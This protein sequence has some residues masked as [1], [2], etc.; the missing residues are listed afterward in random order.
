MI[1]LWIV[2]LLILG[3]SGCGG[4]EDL[5]SDGNPKVEGRWYSVPQ[6]DE[7]RRLYDRLCAS[8]HGTDGVGDPNWRQRDHEG[9]FPP[10]PLNGTAHAWHHSLPQLR[11]TIL[12]GS[13]AGLGRMPPWKDQIDDGQ[14]T[15]I[16]AFFSSLWPERVYQAWAQMSA[17]RDG[18]D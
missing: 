15:A 2:S 8:C 11:Q 7:G 16:I 5:A 14:A 1:R 17:R 9:M 6:V 18:A 13:P 4:D 3:V 12:Q 10:P